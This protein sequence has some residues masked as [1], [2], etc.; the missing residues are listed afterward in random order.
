MP[1]CFPARQI[2]PAALM[3]VA[4][5][6]A[7]ALMG[8]IDPATASA[9]LTAAQS[10]PA[11]FGVYVF[12]NAW[13]AVEIASLLLLVALIGALLIGRRTAG[14]QAGEPEAP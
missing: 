1:R 13:L 12:R 2:W 10:T 11:A 9:P 3:A 6:A 8:R 7:G 4:Y 14:K 5:L